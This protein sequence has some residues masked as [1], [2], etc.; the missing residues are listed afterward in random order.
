MF[1]RTNDADVAARLAVPNTR[2]ALDHARPDFILLRVVARSLIVFDS[3]RPTVEW[4]E[5]ALPPLLRAPLREGIDRGVDFDAFYDDEHMVS[6]LGTRGTPDGEIDREA[7]AQ[8]H[9]NALAGACVAMGLRFAGTADPVAAA[10]LRSLALRFL[11][12]KSRAAAGRG[13]IG[14]L[15]DRPTLETCVGA[16]ATALGCVMAG[17]GDLPRA[18][19]VRV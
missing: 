11:R 3:V 14:K 12:M 2:F 7:L 5:S 19:A 15:V 16:A 13:A 6:V 9:V 17:T 1:M 10:S 8:A 18:A 4:A